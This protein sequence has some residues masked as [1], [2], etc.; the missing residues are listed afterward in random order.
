MAISAKQVN[1]LRQLTGAG[2][3]D[4]KKALTEADG[5]MEKAVEVLRKKGQKLAAKRADKEAKEGSVFAK[6]TEDRKQGVILAINCETDFVAKNEQFEELGQR[7]LE[8]A[9]NNLPATKEEL[10][11]ARMD[12]RTV[13][14]HLTDMIG[15]IGEKLEIKDYIK[16]EGE[17]I[18]EYLH[19]GNKLGVLVELKNPGGE[20]V[21]AGEDIAMQIA[22]MKPVA[23]DKDSVDQDIIERELEIGRDQARAEGKPDNIIEKIAQGKLNKF[24]KENTLLEQIFVKDSSMTVAKYLDSVNKGMTVVDFKRVSVFE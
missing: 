12:D 14:E 3:M 15:K 8:V 13:E 18:V 17:M 10:L 23:V 7:I 19:A 16:V 21:E 24:Y 11:Q 4:C 5:D 6:T 2:M 9:F 1:E 20:A 22:A